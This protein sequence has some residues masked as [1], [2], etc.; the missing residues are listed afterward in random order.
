M[1]PTG[2]AHGLIGKFNS[3]AHSSV[4]KCAVEQVSNKARTRTYRPSDFCI[5]IIALMSNCEFGDRD[6]EV[7]VATG[8]SSQN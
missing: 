1:A 4:M 6:T 8:R 7:K 3:R 5:R 2:I